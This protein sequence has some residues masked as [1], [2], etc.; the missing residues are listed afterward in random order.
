VVRVSE[1]LEIAAENPLSEPPEV[2]PS[3]PEPAMA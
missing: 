3:L 1:A 2:A